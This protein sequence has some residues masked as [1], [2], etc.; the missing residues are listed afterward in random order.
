[1]TPLSP[2]RAPR[3]HYRGIHTRQYWRAVFRLQQRLYG[4]DVKGNLGNLVFLL[5]LGG[6]MAFLADAT[7]ATQEHF[8]AR[9]VRVIDGDTLVIDREYKGASRIRVY[10][11]DCP[12]KGE[13]WAKEA[14]ALT[15]QL[16]EDKRIGLDPHD[17]DR[18]GR[19]VAEVYVDGENLSLA[20][21]SAGLARWYKKY[22]WTRTDFENAEEE[23]KS[24][25]R[26]IWS[27]APLTP[28]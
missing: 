3:P 15:V 25:R 9:V 23:A 24:A 13:K 26:G 1:M 11:I 17:L 10:G 5:V 8:S 7:V 6:W 20:L 22:A 18:Y 16:V 19:L 14:T 27:T 28:A 21:L 2:I 12:E 4:H